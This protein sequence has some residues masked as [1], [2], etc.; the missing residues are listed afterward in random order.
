MHRGPYLKWP[1]GSTQ[2]AACGV[3]VVLLFDFNLI[4]CI[5]S[6]GDSPAPRLYRDSFMSELEQVYDGLT[7]AEYACLGA[8]WILQTFSREDFFEP[9]MF[10]YAVRSACAVLATKGVIPGV[11]DT[12]EFVAALALAP[13][14]DAA[15]DP[16]AAVLTVMRYAPEWNWTLTELVDTAVDAATDPLPD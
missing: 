12:S 14:L 15:P 13:R 6:L 7:D 3:A 9:V 2:C 5:P 1:D 16:A 4:P 8:A 11:L 10:D